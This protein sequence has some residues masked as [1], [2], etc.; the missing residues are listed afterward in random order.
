MMNFAAVFVVRE[1]DDFVGTWFCSQM[2]P[3]DGMMEII[4]EKDCDGNEIKFRT[5]HHKHSKNL[6]NVFT[7][8]IF[9]MMIFLNNN[10]T[11]F[12]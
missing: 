9:A 3:L 5:I 11:L 1:F 10:A 12:I 8:L 7:I 6:T 2:T 4:Y